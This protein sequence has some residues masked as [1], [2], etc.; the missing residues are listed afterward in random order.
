MLIN[1]IKFKWFTKVSI[2]IFYFVCWFLRLISDLK[3]SIL[4][5]LSNKA[6]K[7][8]QSIDKYIKFNRSYFKNKKSYNNG[9]LLV[10]CFPIPDWI[11]INS[12]FLHLLS[13]EH[14]LAIKTYGI[15]K[16]EY[17]TDVLYSS[18]GCNE[19]LRVNLSGPMRKERYRIFCE[20]KRK[21]TSKQDLF[22]LRANGVWIGMDIYESILRSG[23]A[24]V[25]I[26][27]LY[28]W[29]I[30]YDALT[31]LVFFQET[32]E[33]EKIKAVALSHDNYIGMGLI[34]RVA[35]SKNVPVFLAN[36][37]GVLKTTRSHQIYEIY[38]SYQLIFDRL[39]NAQKALGIEWA[40]KILERRITG[41]VGLE[42]SY[43]KK[44]AFHSQII[45]RQLAITKKFKV[46]IAT[47][48]FY[49]SPHGYGNMLFTDF[50]E[51]L[52]FLGLMSLET[53][54]EWYLKPHA[55]YLP[56]TLE[57]L[58]SIEKDFPAFKIIDPGVSWNQLKEE[59][60]TTVLTCYGS[61]GHELPLLGWKVVNACYN[62]HIAY[63]FN[64]HARDLEHYKQLIR[65]LPTLD[66]I[67]D[68]EKIFEFFYV[69]KNLTQ[70]K[71]FF[72][73]SAELIAIKCST[74]EG[75]I[76]VYNNFVDNAPKILGPVSKKMMAYIKSGEKSTNPFL[77]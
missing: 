61:L 1:N 36:P 74:E 76:E 29:R 5:S 43:Q 33:T 77:N 27:A 35:Y 57:V 22:D 38:K 41:E 70:Q 19:H 39:T 34:A 7:K 63:K 49:D 47:H 67:E 72:F 54:F 46:I 30:I 8:T 31:Y 75:E 12:L 56:G 18:F 10:D 28:S 60:A 66:K 50:Y 3:H 26:N 20:I 40:R 44:S 71:D 37:Y 23:V 55:D 68:I 58:R 51:W 11:C 4:S 48:C 64:W 59:G 9:T 2:F 15:H 14:N 65:D 32:F 25:D 6:K 16:R 24:T 17:F 69:H 73:E 62:P 52:K 45:P 21:I 53:D 42:M 13:E